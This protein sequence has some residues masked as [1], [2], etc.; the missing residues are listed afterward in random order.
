MVEE[1]PPGE[2]PAPAED[3]DHAGDRVCA[4]ARDDGSLRRFD[5]ASRTLA[6]PGRVSRGTASPGF[7]PV[8]PDGV[9]RP[10]HA[11]EPGVRRPASPS[12]ILAD[13]RD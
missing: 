11:D 8:S 5:P 7:L 4:L 1:A 6:P 3:L 13:S 10:R 2:D 12:G 9:V